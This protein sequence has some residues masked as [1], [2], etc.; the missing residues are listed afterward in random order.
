MSRLGWLGRKRIPT[1]SWLNRATL[2]E[3]RKW[4]D[5]TG[6]YLAIDPQDGAPAQ[7]LG[8]PVVEAADMD[9]I[10]AGKTPNLFGDFAGYRILDRVGLSVLHDPYSLGSKSQV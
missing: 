4:K 8:R 9:D 1:A 5:N 6:R 2:A 7:L 3:V 10:G